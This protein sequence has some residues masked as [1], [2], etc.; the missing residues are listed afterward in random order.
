ML[1]TIL[2]GLYALNDIIN[3]YLW[4]GIPTVLKG[5]I[6]SFFFAY[7]FR[8]PLK[9]YPYVFYAYPLAILVWYGMRGLGQ[10]IFSREAVSGFWL[11]QISWLSDIMSILSNL[12]LMTSMGIG[13]IT[14]VM[15]IG[16]LPKTPVVIELYKIRSEMSIIGSTL[17]VA[18]GLFRLS[19]ATQ[20][21]NGT[22]TGDF[23]L[24]YLSFG[25][26]G[27]IITLLIV[28]PWITSFPIVRKRMKPRTWKLVQTYTAVPMFIGMLLFGWAFTSHAAVGSY[29]DLLSLSDY[30]INSRGNAISIQNGVNFASSILGSKIYLGLL[31][32]YIVLRI[33]RMG[34][35]KK[36]SGKKATE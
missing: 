32:T 5:I 12:G 10:I 7:I 34:D 33:K 4:L 17:L 23:N 3:A 29:P 20:Y 21:L 13:L 9:K 19:R 25:I 8:K 6:V 28:L 26:I 18:H 36:K 30:V 11:F 15:F 14:I 16:V 27:P 35:R 1:E 2:D 24:Q 31:V 22:Y